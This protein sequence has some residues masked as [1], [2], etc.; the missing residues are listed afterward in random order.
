MKSTTAYFSMEIGI[1]AALPTYSGGLGVLAGDMLRAAADLKVPLVAVTLLHRKG[2][3]HQR[4]NADGWQIEE[5]AAWKVSDY[6]QKMPAQVSVSI[7]SRSV[8]ITCWRFVI[9]GVSGFEI[10]VYFLDT[11]VDGNSDWD[12]RLTDYLYGG[13]DHYRLCQEVVLGIGGARM[14]RALGH[15]DIAQY[16]M[17]EGHSSLLVLELLDEEREKAGRSTILPEDIKAVRERCVFTTHTPVPAGHD[18]FPMELVEKVLGRAEV[19]EM[20]D[21]FCCD[22]QLNLTYLALNLSR[23]INGVAKKHS[24]VSRLMFTT[25]E[26]DAI[27]NGVHTGTWAAPP[28]QKLFDAYIP[29]WRQ[30]NFSLRSALSIPRKEIWAA[31]QEAKRTMMENINRVANSDLNAEVF[32]LGFARRATGYKRWELLFED[33]ERLKNITARFGSIQVIF[34]GKAHPN[35]QTGKQAIQYILQ[36]RETLKQDMKIVFV[37]NYTMDVAKLLV[38]GVDVWLNTPK[39]PLEASGTSGMKAA[40]NGVPSL[41]IL[42]GW[43]L[44]GHIEGVTGWAIGEKHLGNQETQNNANDAHSLYDKLENVILPLFY[45]DRKKFTIVMKH[46][47]AINGSFFNAQRMVQQY[48][49][50]AYYQ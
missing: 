11:D 34:S 12:R 39:P 29:G 35:D 18:R 17:N 24:E 44:E 49:M 19:T 45:Q 43:W 30:D 21:I 15:T 46:A 38:S 5:E 10:P 50:N 22:G 13:D 27:T 32:T 42:D 25:Y 36:M 9:K 20:Q 4:I 26:I 23:H 14:L 40:I 37:E 8:L 2:Y 1:D 41:S 31:H 47:I 7:E 48:V 3:F 33:V 28:L 16:H 6:L